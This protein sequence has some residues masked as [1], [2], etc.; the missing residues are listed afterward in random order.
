M[1]SHGGTARAQRL[2]AE[3]RKAIARLGGLARVTRLPGTYFV[4]ALKLGRLAEIRRRFAAGGGGQRIGK[5]LAS[6]T[7]FLCS[8]FV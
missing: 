1:G 3:G 4:E 7:A 8:L 6:I 5:A 2:C